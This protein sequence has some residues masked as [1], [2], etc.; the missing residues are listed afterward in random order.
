[1]LVFR[2]VR[3]ENSHG[4]KKMKNWKMMFHVNRVIF[5]FKNLNVRGVIILPTQTM[6]CR[7]H[8]KSY[9]PLKLKENYHT[10]QNHKWKKNRVEHL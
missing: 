2:G 7:I 6:H 1:M 5:G 8:V 3:L 4:T 10:L 9:T